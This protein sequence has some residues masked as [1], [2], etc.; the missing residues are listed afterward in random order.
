MQVGS[1]TDLRVW[2]FIP[3]P[4]EPRYAKAA[5]GTEDNFLIYCPPVTYMS[6]CWRAIA[7][8]TDPRFHPSAWRRARRL[9]HVNRTRCT[10]IG[11]YPSTGIMAVLYA[12]NQCQQTTVFGFGENEASAPDTCG[13]SSLCEVGRV[14]PKYYPRLGEPSDAV[15]RARQCRASAAGEIHELRSGKNT[16]GLADYFKEASHYHDVAQ[17][18]AWLARLHQRGAIVWRGRPGKGPALHARGS[19]KMAP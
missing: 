18:W 7:T 9:I 6:S 10:R 12:I 15:Q 4:R 8:D 14:C 13:P 17:E 11:C 3:L 19:H 5:W 16:F 2:G 1:R